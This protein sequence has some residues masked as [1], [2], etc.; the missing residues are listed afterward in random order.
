MM[1]PV[2]NLNQATMTLLTDMVAA[3]SRIE[4]SLATVQTQQGQIMSSVDN[5]TAADTALDTV[6]AQILTDITNLTAQIASLSSGTNPQIDA[7]VNDIN[8]K[9]AELNAAL[10]APPTQ[11]PAPAP[12]SSAAHADQQPVS[13]DE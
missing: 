5:L 3:I 9:V 8:A 7:V 12:T 4:S 11:T 10:T 2:V 1:Q 6:V 13:T